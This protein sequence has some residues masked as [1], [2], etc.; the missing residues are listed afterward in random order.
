M[1]FLRDLVCHS[2]VII[3]RYAREAVAQSLQAERDPWIDSGQE[4]SAREEVDRDR[5]LEISYCHGV[6][7]A[8]PPVRTGPPGIWALSI[9]LGAQSFGFVG[10]NRVRLFW[11][12]VLPVRHYG[13]HIF[14][15]L[16]IPNSV[17]PHHSFHDWL[18]PPLLAKPPTNLWT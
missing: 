13:G 11:A 10:R 16:P 17:L 8:D 1:H 14:L 2:S 9:P 5:E 15:R 12:P 3:P 6:I 4:Q 18:G 7:T